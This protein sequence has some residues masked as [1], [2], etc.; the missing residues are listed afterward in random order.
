MGAQWKQAGCEI[1][2]QKKGRMS[3]KIA[4]GCHLRPSYHKVQDSR[5][6]SARRLKSTRANNLKW[7]PR[8]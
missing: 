5:R 4:R 6:V 7:S 1:N 3:E 2:A 8:V